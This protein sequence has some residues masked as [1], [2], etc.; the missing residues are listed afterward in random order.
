MTHNTGEEEKNQY[1]LQYRL[2][3]KKTITI[4]PCYCE[5]PQSLLV[6]PVANS[7]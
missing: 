1:S 5:T 2:Q 7:N 6:Q 3:I 4:H